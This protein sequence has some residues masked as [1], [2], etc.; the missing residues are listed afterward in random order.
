ME[1]AGD[2]KPEIQRVAP[3]EAES[4]AVQEPG[5]GTGEPSAGKALP[6]VE[7]KRSEVQH[8]LVDMFGKIEVTRENEFTFPYGS[9]RVFIDVFGVDESSSVVNVYA[10]TSVDVPPSE[11]LFRFLALNADAA[12]FGHLGAV[13]REGVVDIVFSHRLL[14]DHLG[15]EELKRT[16]ATVAGAAN[17]VDDV[18]TERFG[19]RRYRDVADGSPPT[20]SRPE[21]GEE[22]PDEQETPGY[23]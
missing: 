13:E 10:V 7:A 3:A 14:G 1:S 12:L 11:Q 22:R 9:T 2:P 8:I 20:D 16:V 21:T 18:I 5:P 17:E 4:Q 6:A 19:G 23:L 15:T